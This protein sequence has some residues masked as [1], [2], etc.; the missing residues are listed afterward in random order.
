MQQQ[1]LN[2]PLNAQAQFRGEAFQEHPYDPNYG[3]PDP[4]RIGSQ[5]LPRSPGHATH[6]VPHGGAYVDR[7]N[8]QAQFRGEEKNAGC[9]QRS[10]VPPLNEKQ[11][12]LNG[13]GPKCARACMC[14]RA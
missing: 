6:H 5:A 2:T 8:S 13:E 11:P 9:L 3:Q 1:Q 14:M 10:P 4:S 12:R 7:L